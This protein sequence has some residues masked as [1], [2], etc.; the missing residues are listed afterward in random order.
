MNSL[1]QLAF[2]GTGLTEN[3]DVGIGAGNLARGFQHGHH[4]R[5]VR[6]E[7]VFWLADLT[8][9]GFEAGGQLAYLQLLG[10]CQSQLV[11]AARFHQIVGCTRQN[12]VHGGV[13]GRV[14]SHYYD[15]H[16]RGLNAHLGQ[17]IQA[18]VFT[19]AQVQKTQVEHLPLQ[20]R[21]GLGRAVG[22]GDGVTLVFEAIEECAQ[23]GRF[24][25]DQQNAALVFF[26]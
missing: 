3:Q 6:I 14:S 8:F 12:G 20:Q 2:T 15:P 19:Q 13:H 5:T 1:R 4:G 21:I 7:P 17:Y 18:I 11:R 22:G 16:P 9:K 25:V 24:M 23:Y 26:G 10:R